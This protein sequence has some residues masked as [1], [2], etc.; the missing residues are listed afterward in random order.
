MWIRYSIGVGLGAAVTVVLLY[1]MQAVISSD[2]N[3]LNEAPPG[4]KI[5]F[6]RLLEDQEV[7]NKT[8]KPKP[9]PPPI[10]MP[11]EIEQP[12]FEVDPH[13][14]VGVFDPPTDTGR[15]DPTP[16]GFSSDGEYLPIVQVEPIYPRRAASKGIEGYVVM[17]LTV[18]PRGTVEDVVVIESQPKHIFDTNAVAAALKN[19]YKPKIVDGR[20]ITV[21]GVR[22]RITFE[23]EDR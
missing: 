21:T 4:A 16:T 12:D 19:K 5:E 3:P 23:L 17:S 11:P 1:I 9:P 8:Q 14:D 6:V 13:G 2:K 7:I 18:T 20:P 10:D 15:F 22:Y